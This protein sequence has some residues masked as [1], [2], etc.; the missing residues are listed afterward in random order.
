MSI[1]SNYTGGKR[2]QPVLMPIGNKCALSQG[3]KKGGGGR[4][5]PLALGGKRRRGKGMKARGH[6]GIVAVR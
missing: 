5:A 2:P 4:K 3:K 6:Y 1:H